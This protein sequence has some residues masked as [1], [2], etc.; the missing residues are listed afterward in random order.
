MEL[1]KKYYLGFLDELMACTG[2]TKA[3]LARSLNTSWQNIQEKFNKGDMKVSKAEQLTESMG[4]T[5][6]FVLDDGVHSLDG[7]SMESNMGG[8]LLR[9]NDLAP[10]ASRLEPLK[11]F[12]RLHG[13]SLKQI[14]EDIGVTVPTLQKYFRE[15]DIYI[16][17]LYWIAEAYGWSVQ[18]QLDKKV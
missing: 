16:S 14:A 2:T 6:K 13:K 4:Y 7:G 15:D 12:L 1:D 5:V 11:L 9:I 10:E 3:D 18:A 17:R 8:L